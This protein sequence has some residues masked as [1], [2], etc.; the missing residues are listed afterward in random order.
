MGRL[1]NSNATVCR[2]DNAAPSDLALSKAPIAV[3]RAS[4]SSSGPPGRKSATRLE[5]SFSNVHRRSSRCISPSIT[6][7]SF[8]DFRSLTP[9]LPYILFAAPLALPSSSAPPLL[10]FRT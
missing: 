3:Y 8:S 5:A 9:S 6:S 10:P 7:C 4:T 2:P 1:V